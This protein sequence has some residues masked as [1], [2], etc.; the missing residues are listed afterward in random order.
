MRNKYSSI[1]IINPVAARPL[2]PVNERRSNP[3]LPSQLTMEVSD[4][5]RA[6]QGNSRATFSSCRS[7]ELPSLRVYGSESTAKVTRS[8]S[9]SGN[10]DVTTSKKRLV[11]SLPPTLASSFLL[12][13]LF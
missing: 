8:V 12:L 6:G 9:D 3:S 11:W 5:K 7:N 2:L 4:T 13:F 1:I 10:N